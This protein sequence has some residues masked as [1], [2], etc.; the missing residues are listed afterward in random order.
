MI[1][2]V[3]KLVACV[4]KVHYPTSDEDLTLVNSPNRFDMR[5][6][7]VFFLYVIL[8]AC[9]TQSTEAQT[10]YITKTGSKYHRGSC[11]YLRKSKI[12]IIIKDAIDRGYEA[13]SVCEPGGLSKEQKTSPAANPNQKT[14]NV[15]DNTKSPSTQQSKESTS[16]QCT[17]TTKAGTRCKRMT[18]NANG[19][20]YQHQ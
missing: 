13:C 9:A 1:R 2:K 14:P 6:L 7:K 5:I 11:Q 18:T 15:S 16:Q 4:G 20:C 8:I 17:G 19:R 10:V 12:P 3:R